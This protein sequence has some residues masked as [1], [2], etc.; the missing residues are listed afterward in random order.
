LYQ[1]LR[2]YEGNATGLFTSF[3][4]NKPQAKQDK[5]I[6]EAK[7]SGLEYLGNPRESHGKLNSSYSSYEWTKCGHRADYQMTHVRMN[8]AVCKECLNDKYKE[9]A[10]AVGYEILGEAENKLVEFRSAKN[11][12]CGHTRDIRYATFTGLTLESVCPTCYDEKLDKEAKEQG[13]TFLG[14]AK[15]HAGTYRRY[16]FN[17][18]GHERD[19]HAPCV[20]IGRFICTG[21]QEDMWRE[22]A[23]EQGLEYIGAPLV[24]DKSKKRFKLPCGCLKDLRVDHVRGGRWCCNTCGDYHYVRPSNV[25]LYKITHDNFSWLKLGYSKDTKLRK[26]SYGLL[27]GCTVELIHHLPIETGYKAMMLESELHR[28]YKQ[29]N[30]DKRQMKLYHTFSGH[31]ECYP[32]IIQ[33]K[34]VNDINN[35]KELNGY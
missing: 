9:Q 4:S 17:A 10:L 14:A 1:R 24:R 13:L 32:I 7:E 22:V 12:K 33:D 18:C 2:D 35:Y 11:L 20:A 27:V 34:L 23:L 29:V 28:K 6:Q 19:I 31:T 15:D 30:L 8:N 3:I 5:Y 21:C 26:N 25:Y 16:R